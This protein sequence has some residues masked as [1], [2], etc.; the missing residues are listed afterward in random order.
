M[1]IPA[2]MKH[3]HPRPC[4]RCGCPPNKAG[5]SEAAIRRG[6]WVCKSCRAAIAHARYLRTPKKLSEHEEQMLV[7]RAKF[8]VAGV[9]IGAYT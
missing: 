1:V 3:R 6:H 9:Q 8:Q 7:I 5:Y 4:S 2:V